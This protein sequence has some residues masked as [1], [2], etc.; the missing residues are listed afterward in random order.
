MQVPPVKGVE[1]KLRDELEIRFDPSDLWRSGSIP[2]L[3]VIRFNSPPLFW[4]GRG[5]EGKSPPAGLS[6]AGVPTVEY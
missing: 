2:P 5:E 1:S 4:E 6:G 3:L